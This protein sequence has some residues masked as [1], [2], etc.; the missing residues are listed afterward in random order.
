[1]MYDGASARWTVEKTRTTVRDQSE[2]CLR[3][4]QQLASAGDADLSAVD[5]LAHGTTVA[6]NTL[7]EERGEPMVLVTTAGFR[8]VLEIRRQIMPHR[9]DAYVPKPLPLVPRNSRLEIDERTLPD[10][11]I[12]RPLEASELVALLEPVRE[13]GVDTVAVCF[14]HS[15]LNP[16]NELAAIAVARSLGFKSVIASHQ[17]LNEHR[18][19]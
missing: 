3:G 2:G 10:G 17:V 18:E 8:D 14:L 15:Y 12:E 7:L 6:T 5:Y 19:Y 9:Y 13:C 11:R 4:L 1:M 16:E